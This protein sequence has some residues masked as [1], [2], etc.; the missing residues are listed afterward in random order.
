MA[1]NKKSFVLYSDYNEV[2][3]ELSNND[4]G[5]LIKHI[6]KYVNDEDPVT[7]NPIVKVSFIPIKL[8]LKRD[9]VKYEDKKEQWS[10]AGKRSAESRRLKKLNESNERS[11][12]STNVKTVSTESTVTV[13]DTVTVNVINKID[14]QALLETLNTAFSRSF[15]LINKKVRSSYEARLKDGYSKDQIMDAINNCK[16]NDYHK[17]KN[18]QYCTPEFFSRAE[19]LDKY[20]N[21]TKQDKVVYAFHNVI[22]D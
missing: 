8:Q 3:S 12:E 1:E 16:I 20:S 17:E 21:V 18:Y 6:L 22:Y 13:N 11:T 5:E 19:T 9:L 2:F 10:E 14:Y 4:A 7:E 15:K